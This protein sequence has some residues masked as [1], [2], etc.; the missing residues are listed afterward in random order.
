MET[1]YSVTKMRRKRRYQT[2]CVCAR[3]Y[4]TM[5]QM[6]LDNC[7]K[8][9][10]HVFAKNHSFTCGCSKKSRGRPKISRG[11]CWGVERSRKVKQRHFIR[12]FCL[13]AARDVH[14]YDGRIYKARK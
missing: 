9:T 14:H 13:Y 5:Q 3:R 10:I 8:K 4:L 2:Y 11:V 12:N 7:T 1:L 6:S